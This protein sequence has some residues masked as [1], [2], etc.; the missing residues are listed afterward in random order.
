MK[1]SIL[2]DVPSVAGYFARIGAE[3]RGLRKGVVKEVKGIYWVDRHIIRFAVDGTVEAPVGYEPSAA[4]QDA[5]KTD[6]K[7]LEWPKP[8]KLAVRNSQVHLP[9]ELNDWPREQL[10][11][12]RDVN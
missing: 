5:I 6:F 11:F 10:Y 3:P 8:V 7:T 1:I 2:T 9:K 4:E 12:F